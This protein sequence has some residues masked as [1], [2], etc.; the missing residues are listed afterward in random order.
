MNC[1]TIAFCS[2][3]GLTTF[4]DLVASLIDDIGVTGPFI[5]ELIGNLDISTHVINGLY[6]ISISSVQEFLS[7]L[8]TWMDALIEVQMMSTRTTCAGIFASF[9]SWPVIESTNLY[10]S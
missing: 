1:I 8:V 5:I 2:I 7:G 4:N 6:V 10:P 3:Q 9:M